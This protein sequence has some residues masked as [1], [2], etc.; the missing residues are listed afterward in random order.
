MP[1]AAG[2]WR[3]P[4]QPLQH[5]ESFTLAQRIGLMGGTFNPIHV[6]H[7][8]MAQEVL[9]QRSL[10]RVLFIPNRL[11]PHR[12]QEAGLVEAEHR[13]VMVCLATG[14]DSRFHASRLEL[15]RPAPSYSVT[16]VAALQTQT[17]EARLFFITGADSLMKYRWKDLDRMLDMLEALVVVSRPG[18]PE[19]DLRRRVADMG[20]VNAD[21]VDLLEAPAIDI[22]A[23][24]IRERLAIGQPIRYMVPEAVEQ[25]IQKYDLYSSIQSSGRSH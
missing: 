19:E 14:A 2:N 21:R 15:D 22:S 12:A 8:I 25:Y 17:P 18:F 24:R 1:Y 23:T 16:T 4:S 20:L 6:G 10:D 5:R 11:P 7:L 13:Y 9:W 3:D